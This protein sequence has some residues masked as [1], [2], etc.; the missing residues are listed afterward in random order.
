LINVSDVFLHVVEAERTDYVVE[1]VGIDILWKLV[2]VRNAETVEYS[3]RS[4]TDMA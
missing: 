2:I 3:V 4:I 1:S